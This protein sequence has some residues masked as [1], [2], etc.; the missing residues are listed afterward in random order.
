M[1]SPINSQSTFLAVNCSSGGIYE[2]KIRKQVCSFNQLTSQRIVIDSNAFLLQEVY[3]FLDDE[4]GG[5]DDSGARDCV[6][7]LSE[8]RDTI[9]L[10]CRHLCLC[11]SCARTLR[12]QGILGFLIQGGNDAA[13]PTTPGGE[14]AGTPGAEATPVATPTSPNNFSLFGAPP[15]LPSAHIQIGP[16]KCPICR[17]VF[18]S[19]CAINLPQANSGVVVE[20]GE[21]SIYV[22]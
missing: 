10:P 7:C 18:H 19:L 12:N 21:V 2:T 5:A 11:R 16:P 13:S 4:T 9:V 15:E 14:Q 6:I 3:G 8:P 22:N 17:Q 20:G 1:P